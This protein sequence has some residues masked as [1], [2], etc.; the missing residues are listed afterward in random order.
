MAVLQQGLTGSQWDTSCFFKYQI[1]PMHNVVH[2]IGRN[3]FCAV[4]DNVH[5]YHVLCAIEIASISVL[6]KITTA[7]TSASAYATAIL[8]CLCN[9]NYKPE[10]FLLSESLAIC[11]IQ[12]LT[13]PHSAL[14]IIP[15]VADPPHCSPMTFIITKEG[16]SSQPASFI[17]VCRQS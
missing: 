2:E 1:A 4:G 11:F 12:Q 3:V 7:H 8:H 10:G 13:L 6:P 16:Q 14:Q 17:A 9:V 5:A 15:A